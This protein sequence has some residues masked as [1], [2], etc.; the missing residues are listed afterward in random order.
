MYFGSF[1]ST[2]LNDDMLWKQNSSISQKTCAWKNNAFACS[3]AINKHKVHSELV[4]MLCSCHETKWT[5]QNCET[6]QY[7]DAVAEI[8]QVEGLLGTGWVEFY[9]AGKRPLKQTKMTFR[10]EHSSFKRSRNESKQFVSNMHF[11]HRSMEPRFCH[12]KKKIKKGNCDFLHNSDFF[13]CNSNIKVRTARVTQNSN[14]FAQ[15]YKFTS[16]NF[17]Y[18]RIARKSSN[19]K[20]KSQNS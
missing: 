18:L 1:L 16:L 2:S 8:R 13:Q 17:D 19:C 3:L 7:L 14:L 12:K 11:M 10:L 15:N 9:P 4:Y 6:N 20:R 5:F